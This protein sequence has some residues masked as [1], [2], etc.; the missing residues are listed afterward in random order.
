MSQESN[1]KL[2]ANAAP[3]AKKNIPALQRPRDEATIERLFRRMFEGMG[4]IVDRSVGREPSATNAESNLSTAL[5]IKRMKRAIDEGVRFDSELGKVAPHL[6]RLK[7]E[8]G[9]HAEAPRDVLA[10]LE[11]ELLAAAIDHINDNRLRTLAPVQIETTVDIFTTGIVVE[12]SFGEHEAELNT[13]LAQASAAREEKAAKSNTGGFRP[14]LKETAAQKTD[15]TVEARFTIDGDSREKRLHFQPGGRRLNVGRA[16]D[17]DF[18]L[19]H[20]SVS[21][22][23]AAI[24][25]NADGTL[26]L[27][28]TGSTNGTFI[29]GRRI[30]YGEARTIEAGDV[31]SFG[32]AEVRFRKL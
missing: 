20:P 18:T 26:I 22:V 6:M 32:D 1:N 2:D 19:D 24:R 28:D 9:T 25:M 17:N 14:P 3:P 7:I 5:L 30:A 10:E 16:L 27:A 11:H 29:N 4:A 15:V 12:P 13:R 23:H 21:K 31:V 8:W